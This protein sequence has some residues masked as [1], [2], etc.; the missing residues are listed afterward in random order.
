MLQPRAGP[1]DHECDFYAEA[2]IPVLPLPAKS[3]KCAC[4]DTARPQ[5]TLKEQTMPRNPPARP[6]NR[7]ARAVASLPES[8]THARSVPTRGGG[9]LRV[10]G[11]VASRAPEAGLAVSVSVAAI[12][13]MGLMW[14]S[15]GEA[16]AA[17]VENIQVT[18][19][20]AYECEGE[21]TAAETL[22]TPLQPLRVDLSASATVNV[23]SGTAF[24]MGSNH[25]IRFMQAPGGQRIRAADGYGIRA[26]NGNPLTRTGE[27]EIRIVA[28]AE[29]ISDRSNGKAGI[30]ARN[31]GRLATDLSISATAVDGGTDGIVALGSGTGSVTVMASGNVSGSNGDGIRATVARGGRD[32]TI[33]ATNVTGTG[34]GG[35]HAV[36]AGSGFTR[37]SLSETAS[38]SDATKDGVHVRN[39]GAGTSMTISVGNVVGGRSGIDAR[40]DGRGAFRIDATGS[41]EGRG[42]HGINAVNNAGTGLSISVGSAVNGTRGDGIRAY[43]GIGS[44]TIETAIVRGADGFGIHATNSG[45]GELSISAAGTVESRGADGDAIYA[46]NSARSGD[47]S[48]SAT[49]V[50]GARGGIRARNLSDGSVSVTTLGAVSGRAGH[51]I[52]V[53]NER[54]GSLSIHARR[55]V[56]ASGSGTFGMQAVNGSAG[57][58]LTITAAAVSGGESGLVATNSGTGRLAISLTGLA[59]GADGHGILAIN[60]NSTSLTILARGA[61]AA[62]TSE[63]GNDGIR[64][65]NRA[66]GELVIDSRSTVRSAAGDGL[67]AMN[68][69]AGGD[70]RISVTSALGGRHG[71]R[72]QASGPGDLII[73]STRTVRGTEDSGLYA[74]H[75]AAGAMEINVLRATGGKHGIHAR[76]DQA[77]AVS[78][79]AAGEVLGGSA[80]G[81]FGIAIESFGSTTIDLEAGASVDSVSKI[82]IAECV[83]NTQSDICERRPDEG[84]NT[85]VTAKAGSEILGAVH[86]AGGSDLLVLAGGA[87]SEAPVLDGGGPAQG[88]DAD[89]DTLRFAGS[90]GRL[91]TDRLAGWE[92]I[93][94]AEGST[95]SIFGRSG[96]NEI[97]DLPKG[98]ALMSGG[99][100]SF[101]NGS[102]NDFVRVDAD[103]EGGGVIRMDADIDKARS[104][105]IRFVREV[106]G[107]TEIDIAFLPGPRLEK[108]AAAALITV[109]TDPRDSVFALAHG[110]VAQSGAFAYDVELSRSPSGIFDIVVGDSRINDVGAVFEAAPTVMLD[111][112]ATAPS[113]DRRNMNRNVTVADI[114]LRT[115]GSDWLRI[116]SE[117]SERG[118]GTQGASHEAET[119]RIQGGI[120]LLTVEIFDGDLFSEFVVQYAETTANVTAPGGATGSVIAGGLGMGP[121]FTWNSPNGDYLDAQYRVNWIKTDYATQ[122]AGILA[123]AREID[124][125]FASVEMGRRFRSQSRWSFVPQGQF[126]WGEIDSGSFETRQGLAVVHDAMTKIS[127][128]LGV[129]ALYEDG[130]YGKARLT[131]SLIQE[132]SNERKTTVGGAIVGDTAESTVIEI[133]F[134]GSVQLFES[135]SFNAEGAYRTTVSEDFLGAGSALG[136]SGSFQWRW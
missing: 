47:L 87:F 129:A 9:L 56:T 11:G 16:A 55:D 103:F 21:I 86:L 132:F 130:A 71:I 48:I 2:C 17:C 14:M 3:G 4:A 25:G 112:F 32:L 133:G 83:R 69:G 58:D 59:N 23:G 104:D 114:P 36:N 106:T 111:A 51:G 50:I 8:G 82:A 109:D 119:S 61:S 67:N 94:I 68:D 98:L 62:G 79:T 31:A 53:V 92:R 97:E 13:A 20:L 100:I 102:P 24:D 72:A 18:E 80:S 57:R 123:E 127:A 35:V 5:P 124:A 12:G 115:S 70:I 131:G 120:D 41:V 121:N 76:R 84:G 85:I 22:S 7:N 126:S 75:G 45:T 60:E 42:L 88:V 134:G 30:F 117:R 63:E 19:A 37:I 49:A 66:G 110:G 101:Q 40:Q 1:L 52:S 73:E 99:A 39:T 105:Q 81:S 33:S 91:Q 116:H 34:G 46:L 108:N 78:I 89:T 74:W 128:R 26:I 38:G 28:T 95:V 96:V 122:Q 44:L 136:F 118:A 65:R 64:A 135:T 10:A 107:T 93:E 113:L 125:R 90:S 29:V 15:A 27:G 43:S 77:G 54:R 6:H